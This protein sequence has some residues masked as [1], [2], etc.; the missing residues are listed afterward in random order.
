MY[1]N[2]A[3]ENWNVRLWIIHRRFMIRITF[4]LQAYNLQ[5]VSIITIFL[6]RLI[7]SSLSVNLTTKCIMYHIDLS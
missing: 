2:W 4:L 3:W 1:T 7:C 6:I 5:R